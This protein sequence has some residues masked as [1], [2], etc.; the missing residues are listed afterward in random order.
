[1]DKDIHVV[2]MAG[3]SGTRFWP[4]SRDAKPKQ[5]LD[6]IG[7][8]RS[9]IQMTYDRFIAI[10]SAD[11]IWIVSNEKY[12]SLIKDQL[13]ELDS[14]KV[15][16]EPDKRNTAPCIAYAAYKVLKRDSNAIMV[17]TPAD[18]A[19][20][21]EN[22]FQNIIHTAINDASKK[23][24]LITIGI[25]PNRPETGY[26]YIQYLSNPDESVKKVKTFTEK[27]QLNL[28]K[29]F[30]D[31]G[32]FLWNSGIF[33]WS[34]DSIVRAFEKH[35]D[36][37]ASLFASGL[38]EYYSNGEKKFIRK[39]YSHC[40]NISIDYA[41][42]EKA[43]N[44]FVIPGNFGWSD[45]GSWNALHELREKD[46]NDNVIEGSAFTYESRDNFIKGKKGKLI[47]TQGLEGYLVAD[48]DDVLLI[49][50]KEDSNAFKEFISDAKINMGDKF[51]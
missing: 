44:V 10:T 47:V 8:G 15:L 19:I 13:P 38:K 35:E 26:G 6:V 31:S 4:Y 27:P 45:L 7:T 36:E 16:L 23:D 37:I 17:V 40:K 11:K 9:L 39:T 12:E 32:D 42:M 20:F 30:L 41:I 14:D 1:M 3:G 2:I 28:A 51:V 43:D 25:R 33:I 18:H 49:C 48:F 29:K 50:K 22:E 46:K 34:I 24:R 21:K 5:F